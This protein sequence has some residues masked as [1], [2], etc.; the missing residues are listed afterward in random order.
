M[1]SGD[2]GAGGEVGAGPSDLSH[3]APAA[4]DADGANGHAG[5]MGAAAAAA[6]ATG[7]AESAVSGK[8]E[9]EA[10]SSASRLLPLA[11]RLP[12]LGYPVLPEEVV[13]EPE[14]DPREMK[15]ME[16][17]LE[18]VKSA[19]APSKA[20]ADILSSIEANAKKDFLAGT[21]EGHNSWL[22]TDHE[23]K[24]CATCFGMLS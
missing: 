21:A 8:V 20:V 14:V 19:I 16:E 13:D 2:S 3:A 18:H 11:G 7:A 12:A 6:A 1:S 10:K 22:L 4:I 24:G 23:A 5:G 9:A 15:E 17:H